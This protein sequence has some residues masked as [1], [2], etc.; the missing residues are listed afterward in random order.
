[1]F[2]EIQ[3]IQA[4]SLWQFILATFVVFPKI[5]IFTF[6]GSRLAKLSDGKQREAMDTSAFSVQTSVDTTNIVVAAT[7]IL[8]I[9][10]T[11]GSVLIAVIS[12]W[13][14]HID[15]DLS[16]VADSQDRV[17]YR[18]MQAEIRKTRGIP[19]EIDELAAEAIENLEEEP[20]LGR[21]PDDNV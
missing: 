17:I 9:A 7:K 19:P 6:V 10:L 14:V 16:E 2:F 20:L 15:S 18:L 8:N 13:S 11:V 1:M 4:V 21:D 3:S 12:S 5:A